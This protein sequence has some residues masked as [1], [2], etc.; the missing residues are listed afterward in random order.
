MTTRRVL[1]ISSAVEVL[2]GLAL[3]ASPTLFLQLLLRAN[4]TDG[5]VALGRVGGFALLSL[6]LSCWPGADVST[7][8]STSALFTYNLLTAL[9]L[10]YLGVS[11]EFVGFLLWLACAL[12]ASLAILLAHSAY[13]GV[14]RERLAIQSSKIG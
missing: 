5:G 12:H 10:M 9:Y 11:R 7:V 13:E 3:I 2:T 8:Q 4:L 14:R 6:G 1:A